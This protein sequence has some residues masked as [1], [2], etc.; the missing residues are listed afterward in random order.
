MALYYPPNQI[1]PNLFANAGEFTF[2]SNNAPFSGS[3][4]Q[5]S[6]GKYYSEA[7]HSNKSQEIIK[8]STI[9]GNQDDAIINSGVLPQVVTI[10]SFNRNNS[11][12]SGVTKAQTRVVK[13]LPINVLNL[14]TAEDYKIG[15]FTRYFAKKINEDSYIEFTKEVY[16]KLVGKDP[17]VYYEQ[18]IA[19]KLSWRLVGDKDKVYSTNRNITDLNIKQLNLFRFGDYLKHNYLKYYR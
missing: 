19:F 1:K 3:Y 17:S 5:L 8:G 16:D 13:E 11:I 9:G 10:N 18:Y 4:H 7:L 12:Y 2:A 15:E 14:P 6:N